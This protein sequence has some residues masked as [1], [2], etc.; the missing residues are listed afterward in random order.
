ML[1]INKPTLNKMLNK[2]DI[3]PAKL[4]MISVGGTNDVHLFKPAREYSLSS[5]VCS[6]GTTRCVGQVTHFHLS[7]TL[8]SRSKRVLLTFAN[9]ITVMIV[10]MLITTRLIDASIGYI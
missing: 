6:Y 1:N 10:C 4:V 8:Q 5:A 3:I 7:I 9:P 2:L